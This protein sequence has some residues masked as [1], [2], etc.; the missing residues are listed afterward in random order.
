MLE[1]NVTANRANNVSVSPC[2][3][4]DR[5]GVVRFSA[6]GDSVGHISNSGDIEVRQVTLDGYCAEAGVSPTIMKVDIEGGEAAALGGSNTVQGLR[7]LVVEIHEPA[8]RE[9]GIDPVSLLESIGAY[10]LLE[11]PEEGNYGVL[12]H[13]K[14]KQA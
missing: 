6:S 3:V 10:E 13:P 1:R 7:D 11:P 2:A 4:G 8:L 9:R 14:S 12:V 5:E